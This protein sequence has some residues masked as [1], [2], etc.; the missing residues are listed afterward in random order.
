MVSTLWQVVF[1]FQ[2]IQK[3]ILGQ[4]FVLALFCLDI[5]NLLALSFLCCCSLSGHMSTDELTLKGKD[6]NSIFY[7][8][9]ITFFSFKLKDSVEMDNK[10]IIQDQDI[11]MTISAVKSHLHPLFYKQ[12]NTI[13]V[14][15]WRSQSL[16]LNSIVI[17]GHYSKQAIHARKPSNVA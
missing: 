15:E 10:R 12:T 4:A 3:E 5:Y 11:L 1:V 8:L 16:D 17:L 9:C 7:Q 13:K 6:R 14:L 2:Q